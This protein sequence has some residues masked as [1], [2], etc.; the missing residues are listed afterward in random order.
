MSTVL[1]V[2]EVA[3]R[4]HM[5]AHMVRK[6]LRE[7]TLPGFKPGKRTWLIPEEELDNGLLQKPQKILLM[8]LRESLRKRTL[9]RSYYGY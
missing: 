1:V 7:G 8:Q 4:I 6:M 9:N 3:T 2:D 5:S